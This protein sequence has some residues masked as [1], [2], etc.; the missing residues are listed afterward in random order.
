M[1]EAIE[2]LMIMNGVKAKWVINYFVVSNKIGI[3]TGVSGRND[4]AEWENAMKVLATG[5]G[6]R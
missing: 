5:G 2:A 4:Y 1:S 3:N 6:V